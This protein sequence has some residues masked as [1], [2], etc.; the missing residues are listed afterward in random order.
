VFAIDPTVVRGMVAD[1]EAIRTHL[2]TQGEVSFAATLEVSIPKV[3]L[4]SAAS[5]VEDQVQRIVLDLF[6]EAM[7]DAPHRVSFVKA[8]GVDRRYH[9][10]FDWDRRNANKFFGLFG[11]DFKE[12]CAQQVRDDPHLSASIAAFMEL[13]DLRNTLVHENFASFPLGKSLAEVEALFNDALQFVEALP[14]LLRRGYPVTRG[15]EAEDPSTSPNH[16]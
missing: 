10:W 3:A 5:W 2:M 6:Q 14:A 7:A 9:T 8:A 12:Y 4:L 1:H 13:G 11:S 15:P 16:G